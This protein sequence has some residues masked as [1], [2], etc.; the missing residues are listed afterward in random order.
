MAVPRGE[1]RRSFGRLVGKLPRPPEPLRAESRAV[2]LS[3]IIHGLG[4]LHTM[5]RTNTKRKRGQDCLAPRLRSG[6]YGGVDDPAYR[7]SRRR[8]YLVSR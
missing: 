5:H 3:G 7:S 6:W 8:Q 1:I 4:Y 2:C